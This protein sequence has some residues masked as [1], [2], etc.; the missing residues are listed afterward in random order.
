MES[1]WST[2]GSSDFDDQSFDIFSTKT[3]VMAQQLDAAFEKYV[4]MPRD[5][6][7]CLTIARHITQAQEQRVLFVPQ[8]AAKAR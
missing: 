6:P 2:T 5:G 7:Q 3:A 1:T 4:G 8:S